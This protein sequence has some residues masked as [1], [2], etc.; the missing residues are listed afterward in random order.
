MDSGERL[1]SIEDRLVAEN[2]RNEDAEAFERLAVLSPAG[3]DRVRKE[4]A[5]KLGIRVDTLDTEVQKMR[6][7][8][9]RKGKVTSCR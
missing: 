6:G 2:K 4:E 1:G 9:T 8:D 7:S 3:Y 5:T